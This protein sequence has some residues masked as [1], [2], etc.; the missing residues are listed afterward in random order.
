MK[1]FA[2]VVVI[3]ACGISC[4][5]SHAQES[6]ARGQDH[7]SLS[8]DKKW[9]YKCVPYGDGLTCFPQIV[10]TGTNEVVMDFK[11]DLTVS[12]SESVDD[13]VVWAP[14]S[15]RFAFNYS[16]LHRHHIEVEMVAFFQ[17]RDDKWVALRPPVEEG[18]DHAQ[19]VELG[20]NLP[21]DFNPS[22]C[23]SERDVLRLRNWTDANT[24]VVYAPCY[25]RASGKLQAGFLF[26]LKFDEAGNWKIVST[27]RMSKKELKQQQ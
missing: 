21:K 11:E 18:S 23:D 1:E 27:H 17:L 24:A 12:S 14:D 2:A 26:T 19:L 16:P 9:E 20:K 13:Q 25:G 15:K 6:P 22:D 8:S 5:V 7:H 3:A 4:G 10:K